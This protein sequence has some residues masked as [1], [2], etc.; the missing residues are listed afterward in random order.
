ELDPGSATEYFRAIIDGDPDST[1]HVPLSPGGGLVTLVEGLSPGAH[2]LELVKETYE[3]DDVVFHGLEIDGVLTAP[4]PA[5]DRRLAFYGDSNLAGYSLTHEENRSGAEYIGSHFGLAGIT[6]RMFGAE[7][8]NV[9]VSGE[10]VSG[11]NRLMDQIDWYDSAGQWDFTQ[12]PADAVIINLGANDVG[13]PE[14]VIRA[15]YATLLDDVRT[16][17]PDAHIVLFNGWG[18]DADEPANYT[19]AVAADYGDDN[20]SVATFPWLFEQW[21]GSEYDHGGMAVVLAAHL[22]DVLGWTAGEADVMSGYGVGGDVANGS[23]EQVAPFG[24]YGWRYFQDA[25]VSRVVDGSAQD[26]SAHVVLSQGAAI[27]QPNPATAGQTVTAT[28]WL[29]GEVGGEDVDLTIDFRDQ[30]MWTDPLG[31]TTETVSLTAD[32]TQ[33]TITAQAPQGAVFHTRLTITA[34][35]G[36]VSVDDIGM[37]TK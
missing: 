17:H 37:Q 21:H 3:W 11:L 8:H 22:S 32:W 5:A 12:F 27:H 10:T 24:G 15:D 30:T 4:P 23:F 2:T 29:R 19:D 35:S 18:W 31:S 14:G 25:G 9:S 28:V 34:T 36:T 1:V 20:L 13:K 33:A 6:A 7:Y 26:G 16:H